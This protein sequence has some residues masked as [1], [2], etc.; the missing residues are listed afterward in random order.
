MPALVNALKSVDFPT[1]GRPTI[2][3]LKPIKIVL[4]ILERIYL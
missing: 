4:N 2:P 1:L 3:Q